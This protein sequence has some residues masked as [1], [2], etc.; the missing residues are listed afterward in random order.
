MEQVRFT[1]LLLWLPLVWV[2]NRHQKVAYKKRQI[3]TKLKQQGC[4]TKGK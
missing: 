4:M 1:K 2:G 3:Q